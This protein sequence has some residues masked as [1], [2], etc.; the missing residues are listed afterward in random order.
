MVKSFITSKWKWN[1]VL[2][3][4]KRSWSTAAHTN[5]RNIQRCRSSVCLEF[6]VSQHQSTFGSRKG[7]RSDRVGEG[8]WITL[9]ETL[10]P[11]DTRLTTLNALRI[12]VCSCTVAALFDTLCRRQ[13]SLW[14][15]L[16][17]LITERLCVTFQRDFTVRTIT[18]SWSDPS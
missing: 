14:V 17:S 9:C 11:A 16:E 7:E 8:P 1:S 10:S 4:N 15:R 12:C 5:S 2:C 6:R 3:L 18:S 13:S